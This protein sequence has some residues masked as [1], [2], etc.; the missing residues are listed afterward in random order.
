VNWDT[1]NKQR[2][3]SDVTD[4]KIDSLAT[5]FRESRRMT[6]EFGRLSH[7]IFA[8]GNLDEDKS[9]KQKNTR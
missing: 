4:V 5:E 7:H 8:T 9:W 1:L 6:L 2:K 3:R